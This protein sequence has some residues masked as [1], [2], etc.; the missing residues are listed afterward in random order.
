MA[1]EWVFALRDF[2]Y[3]ADLG[4]VHT[5][6][7]FQLRGHINDGSLLRHRFVGLLADIPKSKAKL[8]EWLASLPK[9]GECGAVFLEGWQRDR[10]GE[11][12]ELSPVERNAQRRERAHDRFEETVLAERRQMVVGA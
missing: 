5:G 1:D 4:R 7:V 10:C 12:H 8:E 2:G 6:Q 11:D 9:C 3:D